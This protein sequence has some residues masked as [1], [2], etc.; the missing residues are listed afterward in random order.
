MFWIVVLF[1][2]GLAGLAYGWIV[3][4]TSAERVTITVELARI[5]LVI[6]KAKEVA[7][8]AIHGGHHD[9]ERHGQHF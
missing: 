7:I 4:R 8:A 1:V 6:R 3:V 9:R 2:T 5:T